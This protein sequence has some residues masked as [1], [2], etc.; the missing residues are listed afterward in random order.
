MLVT[1][2]QTI[3]KKIT[4]Y[5]WG[6][7]ADYKPEYSTGNDKNKNLTP[8]QFIEVIHRLKNGATN[9]SIEREYNLASGTG[10]RIRHK[11][12][13]ASWWEKYIV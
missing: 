8:D 4:I 5:L 10:S 1:I 9:A 13:Y 11:K 7:F 12:M 2:L 3:K 6:D